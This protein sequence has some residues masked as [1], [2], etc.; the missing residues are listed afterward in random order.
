MKRAEKAITV[1]GALWLSLAAA[2][3]I[4]LA[5]DQSDSKTT[6]PTVA[7]SERVYKRLKA[8]QDLLESKNID[9]AAL[10]LG[11]LESLTKL[12]PYERAQIHNI[13]AYFFYLQEKYPAAIQSYRELLKQE[14][15]P[16]ALV[17]STLKTL[18]QLY[19]ANQQ[20]A[21][22]LAPVKR[23]LA[24]LEAPEA[25][26]YVL[27]GSAYFQLQR[28]D[29]ALAPIKTAIAISHKHGETPRENWLLLLR[30]IY[31]EKKD[32]NNMLVALKELMTYYPKDDYLRAMAGVYSE[33]G[34]THK[35]LA[36][37]EALYENGSLTRPSEIVNLA[38]LFL[39]HGIPYKAAKLLQ[40]ELDAKRV[41]GTV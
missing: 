4:V 31:H 14:P 18:G 6:K 35:Q 12:S 23:L 29:E 22:V 30:V 7:M 33:L 41:E 21:E 39:L 5:A 1:V 34:N 36:V 17:Q 19:F 9:A 24:M 16:E 20:Y 10:K 3:G 37:T 8:I 28:Y 26:L 32:Y 40:K 13:T 15:L 2:A 38:N 27:L 25:E 11:E